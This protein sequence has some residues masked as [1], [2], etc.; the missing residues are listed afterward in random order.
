MVCALVGHLVIWLNPNPQGYTWS[1]SVS[2]LTFLSEKEVV[3]E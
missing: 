1:Y 2:A 3:L